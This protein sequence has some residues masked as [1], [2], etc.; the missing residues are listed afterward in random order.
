VDKFEGKAHGIARKII[1]KGEK[2]CIFE[3]QFLD[4]KPF[5]YGRLIKSDGTVQLQ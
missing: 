5:G 1:R 4:G 2:F 3:G